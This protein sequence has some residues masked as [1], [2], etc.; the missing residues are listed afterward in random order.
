MELNL[1]QIWMLTELQS[2]CSNDD[3]ET[4]VDFF[5]KSGAAEVFY[6]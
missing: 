5:E 6:S 1:N 2:G 3:V 4:I